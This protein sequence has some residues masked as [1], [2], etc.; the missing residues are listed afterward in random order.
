[1]QWRNDDWAR[2]MFAN[3]ATLPPEYQ[4]NPRYP[5]YICF[6]RIDNQIYAVVNAL[7]QGN[8]AGF[9]SYWRP[10]AYFLRYPC[11]AI[12]EFNSWESTYTHRNLPGISATFSALRL[13][14]ERHTA[15]NFLFRKVGNSFRLERRQ[16][17]SPN[18]APTFAAAAPAS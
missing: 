2:G 12:L 7:A 16:D 10:N 5:R 4:S 17:E 18:R 1:M 13:A 3:G 15:T 6:L 8:Q 14:Y 11:G 9:P